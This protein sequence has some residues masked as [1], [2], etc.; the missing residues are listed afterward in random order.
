ME[1][2]H[3]SVTFSDNQ[4]DALSDISFVRLSE[5]KNN[6]S[7]DD[8]SDSEVDDDEFLKVYKANY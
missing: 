3:T 8:C 4:E 6:I 2:L 7:N 5:S 1:K